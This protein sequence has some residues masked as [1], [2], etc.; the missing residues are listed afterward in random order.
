MLHTVLGALLPIVLTLVLGFLAAWHHD[1]TT[2][3]ASVLNRMVMLYALP[4]SLFAGMVTTR[5]S[6]LISDGV[7]AAAIAGAMVLGYVVT[8]L[9]SQYVLRH[10]VGFSALAALSVGGPAVPF[11]GVSVLGY[12]FGSSSAVPIAVAA[13]VMNIVQVPVTIVL[14]SVA[15]ASTDHGSSPASRGLRPHIVHA[16]KEPV[17]WAPILGLVFVLAGVRFPDVLDDSFKLLG[18]A[19]GGVALFASGVILFAQKVSFSRPVVAIVLSRNVVV[20]CLL[21]AVMAAAG[22]SS[23]TIREAVVTLAIPIASI[24]VILAVQYK[25]SERVVASSLFISTVLSIVTLGAFIA[26]T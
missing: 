5:R 23:T 20:P 26:L 12:L 24:S 25:K 8:Y 17:V 14:L 9:V 18:S 19:T 10:D 1:F 11:V 4:L 15:R 6:E 21:W 16:L 3:Q 2:A 22:A 13:L 7:L